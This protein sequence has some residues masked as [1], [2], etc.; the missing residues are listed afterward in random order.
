MANAR[1][2]VEN[3]DELTEPFLRIRHKGCISDFEYMVEIGSSLLWGGGAPY[4]K[5]IIINVARNHSALMR[6]DG[7]RVMVGHPSRLQL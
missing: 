6:S 5:G 7:S 1:I 2:F 4:P 3:P